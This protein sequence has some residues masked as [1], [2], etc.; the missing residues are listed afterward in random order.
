MGSPLLTVYLGQLLTVY[1]GQ[2]DHAWDYAWM[3][4]EQKENRQVGVITWQC[5]VTP[6]VTPRVMGAGRGAMLCLLPLLGHRI[7][8]GG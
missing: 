8:R 3:V 7:G 2:L 1:L 5:L 6:Q 4:G